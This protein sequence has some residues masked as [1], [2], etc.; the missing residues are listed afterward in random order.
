MRL[1]FMVADIVARNMKKKC[2]KCN[3]TFRLQVIQK[4]DFNTVVNDFRADNL[5]IPVTKQR[6]RRY[7]KRRQ[8]F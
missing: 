2:Q 5:G 7:Y 3:E 8:Q 6:W 1:K 4:I